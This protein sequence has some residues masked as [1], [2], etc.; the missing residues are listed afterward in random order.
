LE[1]LKSLLNQSQR[2]NNRQ[3]LTTQVERLQ[4]ELERLQ[5]SEQDR[6]NRLN[7]ASNTTVRGYT[8]KM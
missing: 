5:K 2:P 6:I 8:K 1:E 4:L 3:F 7:N